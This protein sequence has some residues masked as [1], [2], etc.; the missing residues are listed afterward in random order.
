MKTKIDRR[1]VRV[2]MARAGIEELSELA[3]RSG[4][5]PNTIHKVLDSHNWSSRTL[6][7]LAQALDCESTELLTVTAIVQPQ[8][9]LQAQLLAAT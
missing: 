1:K 3:R 9:Q 7:A 2:K 8:T 6:D 4:L 5:H